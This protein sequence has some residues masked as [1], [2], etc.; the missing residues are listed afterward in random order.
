MST[1]DDDAAERADKY[2]QWVRSVLGP[3][4]EDFRER[5]VK[6][7]HEMGQYADLKEKL[8]GIMVR[9]EDGPLEMLTDLGADCFA[10]VKVQDPSKVFVK[11]ALGFHVEFTLPEAISFADVKRSS[12][13][14]AAAK[15]RDSEAEVARDIASAESM[16]RDLRA[17]G[18]AVS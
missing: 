5:A 10:K 3:K 12:L 13:A 8:S 2:E 9:E 14:S 7:E 4:L 17:L 15:L 6:V 1:N 11:V 18:E 16:I